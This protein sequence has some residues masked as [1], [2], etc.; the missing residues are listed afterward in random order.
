MARNRKREKKSSKPASQQPEAFDVF[1]SY[2]SQDL[3]FCHRLAKTLRDQAV[4]VWFDQWE[5]QPGDYLEVK[6]NQGIE[7]SRKMVALF[8][9]RY[10]KQEKE[11]TRAELFSRVHADP[12]NRER[13]VIPICMTP[14]EK[15]KIPTVLQ[16]LVSLDFSNP[17][18]FDLRV[19][20][21][22]EA[23]ELPARRVEREP[24]SN[25]IEEA[26]ELGAPFLDHRITRVEQ[27]RAAARKGELFE[28]E[29]AALYRVLGFEVKQ[30]T[31]IDGVQID[32]EVSK[33][34]GGMT[35]LAMVECKDTRITAKER[36]QL[37]AQQNLVQKS[38]P[39]YRWI[40]LS[41]R[42]F[43]ADTR[44]ALESAGFD[45]TTYAELLHEL[46]PLD[47]YSDNLI[48][49]Y[50][51]QVAD[52][53]KGWGGR[54]LFIR[55]Q[56]ETDV[57]YKPHPALG[58]FANWLGDSRRNLMVVLGDLGTGKTTLARFLAY[59][60]ARS[61]R[62]DPLRHP[63]VLLIPLKEMRKEVALGSLV[64]KH[65]TDQGLQGV[66]FP[67]FEHLL[68]KGKVV[69][70]FDAFDEMA[71]RV[72]WEV[73][74][75]SFQMLNAAAEGSAKVVLTCRTHYFKDR[76]EQ[77]TVIGE[78]PSLSAEETAL[79]QQLRH[80][81]NAEVVYL[82][83]FDQPKIRH[84]LELTRGD[85]AD[86]EWEK[87]RSIYNL[88]NLAQRPLLL[89]MIVKSLPRLEM[90]E[91][92]ATL[93]GHLGYVG[94]VQFSPSG[95]YLVAAGSAGRLQFWDI[96]KQETFLYLY[97]FGPGSY[98]SLLPDGRF[99]ATPD[100]LRYLC[101]TE[102]KGF[103]SFTAEQLYKE[104]YHPEAVKEVLAKYHAPAPTP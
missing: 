78:G 46:L 90:G 17:D 76:K 71:D 39:K 51:S 66:S 67:R 50:E 2:A 5:I 6:L 15:L 26:L 38:F 34:E 33:R 9:P 61:F 87:I 75:Q 73:T 99:D 18:D 47:Q 53:E 84:Y 56:L 21:L 94:L 25:D 41:S 59:Q 93:E 58:Y 40:A 13:R 7:S 30:N 35:T 31:K 4:R 86:A 77:R 1:L 24:V 10:F 60:L 68:R 103:T 45:C 36:D 97:A 29:A 91:L 80:Q 70:F 64:V 12:L 48:A 101:Y 69:L 22:I 82:Q 57:E 96:D 83:E 74:Q 3:D 11:W 89:D 14:R 54:D 79:Y 20:Q 92:L 43:A 49:D 102:R 72:R 98:L 55:P 81:S 52:Q 44:E 62:D 65:F 37:L 100:A 32:L 23:L 42:G 63:A 8:S 19:R 85:Q 88:E 27:G 16:P 28:D 95:H 104:F